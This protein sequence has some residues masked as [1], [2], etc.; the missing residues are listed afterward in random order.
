M[1]KIYSLVLVGGLCLASFSA[2]AQL[3]RVYNE[4]QLLFLKHSGKTVDKDGKVIDLPEDQLQLTKCEIRKRQRIKAREEK[5]ARK[6][7]IKSE[8]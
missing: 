5:R 6:R 8:N 7:K 1:K 4:T 3:R 2:D